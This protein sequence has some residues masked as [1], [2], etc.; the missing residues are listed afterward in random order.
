MIPT[1][2]RLFL[3]AILL[4]NLSAFAQTTPAVFS[5]ESF[6]PKITVQDGANC[7]A[8]ASVY[9]TLSTQYAF[10]NHVM[11]DSSHAF[12]FGYTDGIIAHLG[13]DAV[14][15]L[16][17]QTY[18]GNINDYGN[19]DNALYILQTYGACFFN[20]FPYTK[21]AVI[22][23]HFSTALMQ[24]PPDIKIK[25]IREIVTPAV[26]KMADTIL[27]RVRM[28]VAGGHPVICA[29]KEKTGFCDERFIK[30]ANWS[31]APASNHI[32][33]IVG[34]DATAR[35]LRIKNNFSEDCVFSVPLD[36][37]CAVLSWAYVL[38]LP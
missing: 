33:T 27:N 8:Y 29:I 7:F 1:L 3:P 35:T 20:R 32:V 5:L 38:D 2:K 25:K 37:F 9:V 11:A 22:N 21:E 24:T 19:L 26:Y 18:G 4:V 12:S 36:K 13:P 34:Y 30:P 10:Q 15:R 14:K 16:A 23:A 17:W 31:I 6:T 28:E